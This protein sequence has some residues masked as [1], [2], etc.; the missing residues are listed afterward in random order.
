MATIS[1]DFDRMLEDLRPTTPIVKLT[2][3]VIDDAYVDAI[4]DDLYENG[5]DVEIDHARGAIYAW[6]DEI[7]LTQSQLWGAH[8]YAGRAIWAGAVDTGNQFDEHF[9]YS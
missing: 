7:C 8:Q 3:L 1:R 6:N 4:V 9:I 2:W 5:F